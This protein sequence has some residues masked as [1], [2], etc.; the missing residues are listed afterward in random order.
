MSGVL[1]V[2]M[3]WLTM[4]LRINSAAITQASYQF[5]RLK[6]SIGSK[7]KNCQQQYESDADNGCFVLRLHTYRT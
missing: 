5:H 7:E 3:G 1:L 2:A 6:I 4:K